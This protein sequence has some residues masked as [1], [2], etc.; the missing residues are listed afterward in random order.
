MKFRDP[1]GHKVDK[2]QLGMLFGALV[3]P[4]MG[5]TRE[6]GAFLGHSYMN[7]NVRRSVSYSMRQIRRDGANFFRAMRRDGA[8]YKEQKVQGF[9]RQVYK[10]LNGGKTRENNDFDQAF[11]GYGNMGEIFL[12][13]DLGG[14]AKAN[15]RSEWLKYPWREF[16]KSTVGR[17]DI[18]TLILRN[19]ACVAFAGNV[20]L[21]VY[22]IA[23]FNPS[24]ASTSILGIKIAI[25]GER[26]RN[27]YVAYQIYD[28]NNG[29]YQSAKSSQ[30]CKA[31]SI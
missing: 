13:S 15:A 1:D 27:L 8:E 17:S 5:L 26:L 7:D 22:S 3:A 4:Q 16:A 18:G 11:A 12:R 29:A 21:L 2:Y 19:Q 31:D 6:E 20:A 14:F 30:T 24:G 23:T 10:L 28:V 9:N 25:E